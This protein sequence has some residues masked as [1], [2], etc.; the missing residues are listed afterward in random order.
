MSGLYRNRMCTS[1]TRQVQLA[2]RCQLSFDNHG[3]SK[4]K[5][6]DLPQRYPGADNLGRCRIRP[7]TISEEDSSKMSL[8]FW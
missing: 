4:A 6:S 1:F 8:A 2:L 3:A 7:M 5:N